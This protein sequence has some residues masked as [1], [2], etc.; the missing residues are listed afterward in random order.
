MT[1]IGF[2]EALAEVPKYILDCPIS[3]NWIEFKNETYFAMLNYERS[4]K[5]KRAMVDLSYCATRAFN[6]VVI[7]TVQYSKSNFKESPLDK[8]YFS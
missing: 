2:E 8:T 6:G 5:A 7:K 4:V 3:A 1:N